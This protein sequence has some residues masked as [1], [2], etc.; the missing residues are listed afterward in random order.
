[1]IVE[2]L[3][4]CLLTCECCMLG[5]TILLPPPVSCFLACCEVCCFLALDTVVGILAA[6]YTVVKWIA[7]AFTTI[8]AL[9]ATCAAVSVSISICVLLSVV[10]PVTIM[11]AVVM[12]VYKWIR[13]MYVHRTVEIPAGQFY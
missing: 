7:Y 4:G 3:G 11:A 2:I 10:V 6:I 1:M 12:I 13:N 5:V 8:C 9:C